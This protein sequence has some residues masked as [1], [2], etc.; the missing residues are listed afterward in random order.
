MISR[1]KVEKSRES[2]SG[3]RARGTRFFLLISTFLYFM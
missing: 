1:N 3:A 2:R